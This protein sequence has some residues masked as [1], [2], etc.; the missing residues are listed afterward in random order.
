MPPTESIDR[1]ELI[2]EIWKAHGK[3]YFVARRF[4][5][6]AKTIY[7]YINRYATVAQAVEDARA[8][9]DEM[10]VDTAEVRLMNKVKDGEWQAV[11]FALETKGRQRG[12]DNSL[13]VTG[14]E[15]GPQRIVIEYEDYDGG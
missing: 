8:S 4:G 2:N 5:V 9:F 3:V 10:L 15:G 12:Y 7:N 11:R 6:S 13:S 14:P 1:E